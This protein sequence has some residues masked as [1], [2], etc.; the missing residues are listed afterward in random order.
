ML[1]MR[2][3]WEHGVSVGVGSS[4]AKWVDASHD[5]RFPTLFITLRTCLLTSESWLSTSSCV[6]TEIYIY[7]KISGQGL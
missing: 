7:D 4:A 5:G 1:L 3:K 6:R 2:G